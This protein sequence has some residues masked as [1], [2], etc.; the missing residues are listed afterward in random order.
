MEIGVEH[1]PDIGPDALGGMPR[2]ARRLRAMKASQLRSG[3]P[4]GLPEPGR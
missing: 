2:A 1:V 4:G 3:K